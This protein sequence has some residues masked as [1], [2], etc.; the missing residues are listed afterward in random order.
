MPALN[1]KRPSA[2]SIIG[3]NQER[4]GKTPLFFM[5]LVKLKNAGESQLRR[6]SLYSP[7]SGL[8]IYYGFVGSSELRLNLSKRILEL[9]DE[10][11]RGTNL[12]ADM[13]KWT[14]QADEPFKALV[15]LAICKVKE[16]SDK[17]F[18]RPD[19]DWMIKSCWGA[20]YKKGDFAR[21]HDHYPAIWSL[22]YYVSAPHNSSPLEFP[23]PSV[24]IKPSDGL[25]LIFPGNIEHQV[26]KSAID[27]D[28]IVV[29][30]N[31]YLNIKDVAEH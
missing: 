25:L 29:S 31:F 5:K 30:M 4:G 27:N 17:F 21:L 15:D 16:V 26:P 12:N 14:M 23:G 2:A 3:R 19:I 8:Y 10:Q 11:K 7:Q 22:V 18:N 28:R 20:R 9:G 1:L 13:T 6:F 24:A